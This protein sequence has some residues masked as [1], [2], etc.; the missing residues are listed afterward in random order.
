[1]LVRKISPSEYLTWETKQCERLLKGMNAY[2]MDDEKFGKTML[3]GK[4]AVKPAKTLL[5]DFKKS[6]TRPET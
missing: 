1:M 4:L 6:L 3:E 5:V 2:K